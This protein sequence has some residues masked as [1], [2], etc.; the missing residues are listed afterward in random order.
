MYLRTD[1]LGGKTIERKRA[2]SEHD[3]EILTEEAVREDPSS[4]RDGGWT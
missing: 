4:A 1:G 2:K 3:G